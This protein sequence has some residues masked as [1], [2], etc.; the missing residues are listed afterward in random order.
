[1][2]YK[3]QNLKKIW[4]LDWVTYG[5]KTALEVYCYISVHSVGVKDL[6][7]D[8]E[9]KRWNRIRKL[10]NLWIWIFENWS[11]NPT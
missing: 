8:L 5:K 4:G 2:N 11:T 6:G 1:M 9:K 7:S 10:K 3:V